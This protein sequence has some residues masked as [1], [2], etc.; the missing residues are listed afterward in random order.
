MVRDRNGL[1]KG[2]VGINPGSETQLPF[3]AMASDIS[4]LNAIGANV[5]R[6]APPHGGVEIYHK[7]QNFAVN[8]KDGI[9]QAIDD[10]YT[11]NPSATVIDI[12][13]IRRDLDALNGLTI[14]RQEELLHQIAGGYGIEIPYGV[15]KLSEKKFGNLYESP[16]ILTNI[17][18]AL[19]KK[20]ISEGIGDFEIL[21]PEGLYS[22]AAGLEGKFN[23]TVVGD[24]GNSFATM[25]NVDGT[26]KVLGTA[27]NG[28][29]NHGYNG[30]VVVYDIVTE[31][32]G[33]TNQNI[34]ILVL[35]GATERTGAQMRGG[36]LVTF[37]LGYNSGLF[38][39][40]GVLINLDPTKPGEEI[41]AGMTGGVMYVPENATLGRNAK[42]MPLDADDYETIQLTLTKH[43]DILDIGELA[44]FSPANSVLQIVNPVLQRTNGS[45]HM[46]DFK[47]FVKIVPK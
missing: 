3:V 32:A 21:K 36:S 28:L 33:L 20:G 13:E 40:A 24:V 4:A 41:G 38:M 42:K 47:N 22:L 18:N 1:R 25:S 16:L 27:E 45:P 9:R 17:V 29:A 6:H 39:N 37:G 10:L 26:L 35:G 34:D 46:Y 44:S 14:T 12:N 8:G 23:L 7:G 31:L 2:M 11:P 43:T 30:R 5:E 19:L 15:I